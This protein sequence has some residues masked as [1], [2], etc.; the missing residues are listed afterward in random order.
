M[1]AIALQRPLSKPTR[2]GF[3]GLFNTTS[4]RRLRRG[5]FSS[6]YSYLITMLIDMN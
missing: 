6:N 5:K 1:D 3:L 2:P 4:L